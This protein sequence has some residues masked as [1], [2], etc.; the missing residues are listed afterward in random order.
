MRF[1][2]GIALLVAIA[3]VPL[4]A[5]AQ[6]PAGPYAASNLKAACATAIQSGV[7]ATPETAGKEGLCLGV[8]STVL[9]FGPQMNERFRFCT[10]PSITVN[11][12]IPA[13]LKFIEANP[14]MNGLDI[15]DVANAAGRAMWPCN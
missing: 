7:K 10:P 6:T 3:A 15:R 14:Q 4:G 13:L 1:L 2:N 11:E 8:V 5:A 12:A 9:R